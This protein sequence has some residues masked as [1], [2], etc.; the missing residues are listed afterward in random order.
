[1]DTQGFDREKFEKDK[2]S[3]SSKAL[4]AK[5]AR[6]LEEILRDLDSR[7]KANIDFADYEKYYR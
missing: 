5:K 2:A 7:N 4:E 3:Y 6:R 1:M